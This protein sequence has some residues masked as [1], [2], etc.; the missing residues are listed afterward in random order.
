LNVDHSICGIRP[1][2]AI[3]SVVLVAQLGVHAAMAHKAVVV[4]T[5]GSVTS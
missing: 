2:V 1:V 3:L 4:K 5:V